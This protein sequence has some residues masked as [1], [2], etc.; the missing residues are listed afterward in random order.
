[1][2]LDWWRWLTISTFK[3]EAFKLAVVRRA[4]NSSLGHRQDLI[5]SEW[6]ESSMGFKSQAEEPSSFTFENL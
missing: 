3:S 1:V 2:A 4:S 5:R 6:K